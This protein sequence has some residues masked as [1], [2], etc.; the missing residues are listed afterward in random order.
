MK[1]YWLSIVLVVLIVVSLGNFY[2]ESSL[3]S[4]PSFTLAKIEGD[5]K[6]AAAVVVQGSFAKSNGFVRIG[7]TGSTYDSEQTYLEQFA[8]LYFPAENG[9]GQLAQLKKEHR[10]FM[11]G[12]HNIYGFY[13]DKQMLADVELISIYNNVK[14]NFRLKVS[15]LDKEDNR[16]HESQVTIPKESEYQ[17][18]TIQDVQIVGKQLKVLTQNAIQNA[19]SS[20]IG[21]RTESHIYSIDVAGEKIVD[22]LISGK[23]KQINANEELRFS[24]VNNTNPLKPSERAIYQ[25]TTTKIKK[26]S[27]NSYES[28]ALDYSFRV[29]NLKTGKEECFPFPLTKP[30]P[31]KNV[32]YYVAGNRLLGLTSDSAEIIIER[33]NL[34]ERKSEPAVSFALKDLQT[35]SIMS[36]QF[37]ERNMYMVTNANQTTSQVVIIV[38]LASG[39]IV[40]K[41]T[42]VTE[43]SNTEKAERLNKLHIFN[44]Q[45]TQ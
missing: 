12:K 33:Y 28:T 17:W 19:E 32:N 35:D 29:Y 5:E 21:D 14:R 40:Y 22:D 3:N 24:L 2:I 37:D 38:D 43:G 41:G 1:R 42:I 34:A 18:L 27:N 44:L 39:H 20:R 11:R 16:V 25:L 13:E 7:Q 30:A 8:D 6:Q 45:L 36:Y 26:T 9:L 10:S 23:D 15:M 4:L 31:G